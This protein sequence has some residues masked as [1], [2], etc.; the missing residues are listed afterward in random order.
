MPAITSKTL[1]VTLWYALCTCCV[2]ISLPVCALVCIRR[3][4][5]LA[6]IRLIHV[7][8]SEGVRKFPDRFKMKVTSFSKTC[9]K[10][11]SGHPGKVHGISVD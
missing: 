11:T 3:T 4:C 1:P 7:R 6:F 5:E 10:E 8:S 2:C 9:I